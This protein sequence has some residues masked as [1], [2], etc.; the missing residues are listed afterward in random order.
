MIIEN[1]VIIDSIR[2]PIGR[3]KGGGF[4][5]V[6]AEEL[7]THLM[8]QSL[9]HNS[10][11]NNNKNDIDDIIWWCAQQILAQGFNIARNAALLTDIPHCTCR[12]G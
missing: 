9:S 2:T 4:R 7:S 8:T 11:L 12:N 1:I 6:R 3:S 10:A 5:Q